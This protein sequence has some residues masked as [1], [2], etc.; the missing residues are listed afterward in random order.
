VSGGYLFLSLI[1]S[2]V[3]VGYFLYGKKASRP[4]ALSAG[5]IM[6]VFPYFVTNLIAMTI[7]WALLCSSPF[8]A[9]RLGL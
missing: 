9:R 1:V 5:I 4:I 3:G 2:S 7:I 6:M 8:I